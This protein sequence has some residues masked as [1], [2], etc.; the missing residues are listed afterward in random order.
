MARCAE[1]VHELEAEKLASASMA[2]LGLPDRIRKAVFVAPFVV[3]LHVLFIKGTVFDGRA[4]LYYAVQRSVA[5]MILSLH[6]LQRRLR[7]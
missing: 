3:F 1:S 6:L 5:E 7:R 4:G 2:D